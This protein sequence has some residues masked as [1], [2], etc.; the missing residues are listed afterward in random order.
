M[1]KA[2]EGWT[3]H[4]VSPDR[5]LNEGVALDL[6]VY[7]GALWSLVGVLSERS[8]AQGNQRIDILTLAM[9]DGAIGQIIPSF[10]RQVVR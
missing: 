1:N 10:E 7:D 8:V 9:G 6:S 5:C 3:C 4:D 2:M